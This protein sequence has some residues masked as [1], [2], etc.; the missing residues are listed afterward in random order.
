MALITYFYGLPNRI[1]ISMARAH[2]DHYIWQKSEEL[3]L[4]Y[5]YDYYIFSVGSTNNNALHFDFNSFGTVFKRRLWA[6]K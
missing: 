3:F 4:F 5:Y 2:C 6:A 1:R